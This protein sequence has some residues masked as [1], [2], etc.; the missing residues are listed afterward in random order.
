MCD[1]DHAAVWAYESAGCRPTAWEKWIAE[2]ESLLGHSADGDQDA[3]G[4]SLDSFY[5]Q[6]ESSLSPADAVAALPHRCG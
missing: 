3:D 6:W 2:V 5:A 1:D 4:Y